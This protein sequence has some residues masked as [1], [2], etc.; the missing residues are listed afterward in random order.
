MCSAP[1]DPV[2]Q[3]NMLQRIIQTIAETTVQFPVS[4]MLVPLE[5]VLDWLLD[6]ASSEER[7]VEQ[8]EFFRRGFWPRWQEIAKRALS[9]NPRSISDQA[10]QQPSYNPLPSAESWGVELTHALRAVLT[11][12]YEL[13]DEAAG[14]L[15]TH[16]RARS[17]A[18]AIRARAAPLVLPVLSFSPLQESE[19]HAVVAR[20]GELIDLARRFEGVALVWLI[21]GFSRDV[22]GRLQLRPQVSLQPPPSG[23]RVKPIRILLGTAYEQQCLTL[24]PLVQAVQGSQSRPS[25]LVRDR[26]TWHRLAVQLYVSTDEYVLLNL[27]QLGDVEREI[28]RRFMYLDQNPLAPQVVEGEVEPVPRPWQARPVLS[29]PAPSPTS[30]RPTS[31]PLPEVAIDSVNQ[32]DAAPPSSGQA[33]LRED[34]EGLRQKGMAIARTD[35]VTAQKYLLASTVLDNTSVDVWLTLIEIATSERQRA[36]F[37]QEAEKLLQRQRRTT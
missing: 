23:T 24:L 37:R 9:A 31:G 25:D 7:W 18:R 19:W 13:N 27:E 22:E 34:A 32:V 20:I 5:D 1:L 30:A 4:Q 10:L 14:V 33:T 26:T 17:F 15:P 36:S 29:M 21:G 35:P 6:E 3:A 2:G 12:V 16:E 8:L 28:M 11:E